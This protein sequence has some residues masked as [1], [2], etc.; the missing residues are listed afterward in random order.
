MITWRRLESSDVANKPRGVA[1]VCCER[2]EVVRRDQAPDFRWVAIS[3]ADVVSKGGARL[4]VSQHIERWRESSEIQLDEDE[5]VGVALRGHVHWPAGDVLRWAFSE[6]PC[7]HLDRF[8]ETIDN[9]D[10]VVTG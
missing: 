2:R 6:L 7:L 10:D 5:E 8:S 3:T 9:Y 4:G 1:V